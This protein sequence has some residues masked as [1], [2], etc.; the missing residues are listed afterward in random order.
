MPG[1]VR[2]KVKEH[3]GFKTVPYYPCVDEKGVAWG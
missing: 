3:Y 2:E 1:G